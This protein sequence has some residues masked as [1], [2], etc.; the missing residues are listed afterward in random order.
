M[1][2]AAQLRKACLAQPEAEQVERDRRRAW[3][4]DGSVFA[5]LDVDGSARLDLARADA[6]RMAEELHEVVVRRARGDRTS[7]AFDLAAIN[8]MALNYWVR[9][10]WRHRAPRRLVAEQ[11]D[12]VQAADTVATDLPAVGRPAT[13]ALHAAGVRSLDDVASRS[14]KEVGALHGVGPKAVRILQEALAD[15]GISW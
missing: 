7:V 13:R 14:P 3:I 9:Q 1:T 10:A 6:E 4:V 15:R 5:A 11:D 2:T 8:G 12:A